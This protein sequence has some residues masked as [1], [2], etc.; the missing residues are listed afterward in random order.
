M[1]VI[2][3]NKGIKTDLFFIPPFTLYEG[4]IIVLYLH[5]TKYTYENEMYLKNIFC[6]TV[7]HDNVVLD[8][9]MT[10]VDYFRESN[11]RDTFF[12]STINKFIKKDAD[13]AN[14]FLVKLFEDKYVTGKTKMHNLG[15]TQRKLLNLY[16]TL[17]KTK[18]IVFDLGGI[19]PQGCVLTFKLVQEAVRD[20]GSAI[21]LTGFDNLKEYAPKFVTIEW[22]DGDT[23]LGNEFHFNF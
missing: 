23:P 15:G 7:K 2:L 3:K 20:N 22:N 9:K 12:P 13:L 16:K 18:D 17:L 6:G 11:F 10:F 14:P 21:I 19:D 1:K 8:R 4:E 5:N